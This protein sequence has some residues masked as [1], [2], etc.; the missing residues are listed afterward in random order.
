MEEQWKPY[1]FYTSIYRVSNTGRIKKYKDGEDL[2]IIES[3][4]AVLLKNKWGK[5]QITIQRL[6]AICFLGMPDDEEH[7]AYRIDPNKPYTLD[8]IDW[9]TK[10][11][12]SAN[13]CRRWN[14]DYRSL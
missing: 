6:M 8:N 7:K 13:C 12:V 4:G 10:R 1:K 14:N 3:N 11:E 9:G 5:R 2:H